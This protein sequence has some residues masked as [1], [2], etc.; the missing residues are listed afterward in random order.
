M[1]INL[2]KMT[3]RTLQTCMH[4]NTSTVTAHVQSPT[5]F[6]KPRCLLEL[7]SFFNTFCY[8]ISQTI[9]QI[10]VV[11]Q[12]E[13]PPVNKFITKTIMI[14]DETTFFNLSYKS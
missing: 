2:Y 5:V 6:S 8:F 3:S 4:L 9:N 12:K 13:G 7:D 1:P 10:F 11:V 14:T